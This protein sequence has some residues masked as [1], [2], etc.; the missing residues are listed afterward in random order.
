MS[1]V[2]S[3]IMWV[4]GVFIALVAIWGLVDAFGGT[5]NVLPYFGGDTAILWPV[6]AIAAIMVAL[7]RRA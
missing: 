5:G 7:F 4:L 2:F 1:K 3:V 6:L